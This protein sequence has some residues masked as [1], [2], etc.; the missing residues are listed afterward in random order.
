MIHYDIKISDALQLI[1][2]NIFYKTF[3]SLKFYKDNDKERLN[4][5]KNIIEICGGQI[6]EKEN[7]KKKY[8][9]LFFVCSKED[10]SSLKDKI[11]KELIIYENSKLIN[12]KYILDSYYF[13]TNLEEEIDNPEYSFDISNNEDFS[14]Y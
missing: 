1:R 2:F 6:Y 13:L 3:F 14:N 7:Y 11:K 8:E 9:K 12:D 5:L 10:Y 4:I